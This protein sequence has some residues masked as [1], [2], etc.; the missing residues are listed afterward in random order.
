MS[1]TEILNHIWLGLTSSFIG[2]LPLSMLNLTILQLTLSN[3]QQQA[4]SFSLG[5]SVVEFFQICIT[6]L[7]MNVLLTIPYLSSIFAVISIPILIYLAIKNLKKKPDTEWVK[8]LPQNAFYQGI[9]LGFANIV[10]YPF[11]LLWGNVF[12]QNGWLKP[13]PV[14]YF[15]FSLAAAVGTFA[16]FLVFI[17]LGKLLWKRLLWLQKI[18]DK[19]IAFAFLGFAALQFYTILIKI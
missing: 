13:E 7:G 8:L 16:G 11:W 6:L 3:R 17:L 9:V 15:Y 18:M 10:V 1:Y 4:I 14:A 12:V 19:L 2:T 5:A